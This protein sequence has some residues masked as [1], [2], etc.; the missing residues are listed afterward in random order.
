[1]GLSERSTSVFFTYGPEKD[2][3]FEGFAGMTL[4]DALKAVKI[5]MNTPE[6][7]DAILGDGKTIKGDYVLQGGEQIY[8]SKPAGDKGE[9]G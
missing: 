2:K 1:M 3:E 4:N 7:P 8:L 6:K 5:V 9:V